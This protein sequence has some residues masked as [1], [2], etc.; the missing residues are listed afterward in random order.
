MPF[1]KNSQVNT[2]LC[3]FNTVLKIHYLVKGHWLATP[4]SSARLFPVSDY[5]EWTIMK[6]GGM[7]IVK[8]ES[9]RWGGSSFR[10]MLKSGRFLRNLHIPFLSDFTNFNLTRNG[11]VIPLLHIPASMRYH[12]HYQS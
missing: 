7:D 8:Q 3:K 12:L 9:L 11:G 10:Y 5:Y 6:K 4:T 2:P 1:F